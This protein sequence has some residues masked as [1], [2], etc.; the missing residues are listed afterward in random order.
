MKKLS[1]CWRRSK[2]RDYGPLERRGWRGLV[3]VALTGLLLSWAWPLEARAHR[4]GGLSLSR[5]VAASSL[6]V[7]T[8][9]PENLSGPLELT[10]QAYF[11]RLRALEKTGRTQE[12]SELGLRLINLFPRTPQG[13]A[14]LLLLAGLARR[15]GDFPRALELYGLAASVL[16]GNTTANRARHEAAC[17]ELELQLQTSDPLPALRR[18]LEHLRAS[19]KEEAAPQLREALSR[20]WEVV[21]Q[22]VRA[23]SPPPLPLVE[24]VLLL[25]EM[26]PEGWGPPEAAELLAELLKEHHLWEAAQAILSKVDTTRLKSQESQKKG[27]LLDPAR[28]FRHWSGGGNALS[29]PPSR[30]GESLALGGYGWGS[31]LALNLSPSHFFPASAG[32]EIQAPMLSSPATREE[33]N[34]PGKLQPGPANNPGAAEL[35]LFSQD[36]AGLSHLRGGQLEAAQMVFS[37]LAQQDDPFWQLLGQVRLTD[38]ELARW[39]AAASP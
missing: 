9:I 31:P 39:Q 1:A 20:G 33:S 18:F 30:E 13:E 36:R 37:G 24:E 28:L 11:E 34:Q 22:Q 15:Q 27:G 4:R 26:Q 23:V 5:P 8:P 35:A 38:L 29:F 12:A 14:A 17:L 3:T 2:T 16:T 21:A 7:S 10:P 25:W 6:P 32:A 19:P